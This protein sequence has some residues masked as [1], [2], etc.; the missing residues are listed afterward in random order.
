MKKFLPLFLSVVFLATVAEAQYVT[1]PDSNFSQLLQFIYPTCFNSSG[2]MDTTCS[3]IVN[4]TNLS[5]IDYQIKNLNGIQYF[6]SLKHLDIDGNNL[7]LT[8]P[9]LPN[10]LTYLSLSFF[11]QVNFPISTLPDLLDSLILSNNNFTG[12]LPSLPNS[13]TYFNCFNNDEL[14]NIPSLPNSLTSLECTNN[15]SLMSL[16]TLPASL[17][18]LDCSDNQLTNLP[19]LPSSLTYLD[20]SENALTS[21]P[22]L[23]SSLTYL[24]CSDNQLL[25]SLP[26][27]PNSLTYLSCSRSEVISLPTLPSSLKHLEFAENSSSSNLDATSLPALPNSLEYLD[28]SNNAITSLP[29]LPTSL[30]YLQVGGNKLTSLPTLPAS[31]KQLACSSN[32]LTY[33]PTLPNSI[34][35]L[36]VGGNPFTTLPALPTSL[37]FLSCASDSI[38]T[39]PNLPNSITYLEVG[40]NPF[41]TLPALPTSL[42]FLGCASDSITT[43]PNLPNSIAYI[44][45]SSDKLS[46]LPTLPASLTSLICSKNP[47]TSL[48]ALPVGI[49]SLDCS[50]TT[51]SA[52][53]ALPNSLGFLDCSFNKNLNCLPQLPDN[54]GNLP[55]LFLR[56]DT[57]RI[58]CLPNSVTNLYLSVFVYDSSLEVL[59]ST[60]LYS[61]PICNPTNNINH[62]QSFPVMVGNTFY[63]NN[64]NGIKDPTELYIPYVK[65]QLS[66]GSYTFS[67]NKG[68]YQIS[69]NDGTGTYTLFATPPHYY[70]AVPTFLNYNFTNFDTLVTKDIAMQP[71]AFVD[72]LSLFTY[73]YQ[74][75]ARPGFDFPVYVSYANV[76]TTTLSPIIT[77]NYDNTRLTYDSSSNPNVINNG[78][79]LSLS[80][81]NFTPGQRNSFIAYF[82][83][84]ATDVIGDTIKTTASIAANAFTDTIFTAT[85]ISGSFD[86]NDKEATPQL[87]PQQVTKGKS[88]NYTIR[89]QNTGNDTAFNVVIADTLSSLL[90][91]NTLQ[92]ISTSQPCKVTVTGNIVYF[93]FLNILL[94]DNK[95]NDIGS[96]GY[97][98]FSVQPQT[99]VSN[100]TTINNIAS[101]YFD[102]NTPIVTNTAVTSIQETNSTVPVRL[103]SLAALTQQGSGNILLHWS[104]ASEINTKTFVIE[105]SNDGVNFTTLATVPAKGYGANS[106]SFT[107]TDNAAIYYRLKMVDNNG[108]YTYSSIVSIKSAQ[109]TEGIIIVNNPAVNFVT[110]KNN[111]TALIN[112]EAKILDGHGAIVK[113]FILQAGTQSI[114]VSNLPAGGYYIETLTTPLK[115]IIAR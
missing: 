26:P 14:K 27:L 88:I 30:T 96:N 10:S 75:R 29:N 111:T 43:L 109:E 63:D 68:Y 72:S 70:K 42:V 78:N 40:G 66:N 98:S 82:T 37:V 95:T 33:L 71:T 112:T 76:G 103:L 19:S 44:N 16:P 83:A 114:D 84:K 22:A 15:L 13:L 24:D 7:F 91:A 106:Y 21:L 49:D 25:T 5:I 74:L 48:P 32:E 93:E 9:S 85:A 55:Y 113:R 18:Y 61:F 59:N 51:L 56:I 17:T 31:L 53:P 89:F 107:V 6:K 50:S 100:G 69:A 34:T 2:M 41:T 47:L 73:N 35:Y 58:H 104:T 28:C 52:L 20:C 62:C 65:M 86:P 11:E 101:I 90:Q 92:M 77:F 99:S 45:C 87:T 97:V 4:E 57:T 108:A 54:K 1:I 105:Q 23:Q 36:Q 81:T 102:Y 80:E 38:S 3:A 115:F 8:I 39:L 110:V 94:P 79:S 67:D 64:S 12:S 60:S 46:T